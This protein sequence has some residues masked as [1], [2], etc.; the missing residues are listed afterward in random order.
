MKRRKKNLHLETKLKQVKS[1]CRVRAYIIPPGSPNEK[2]TSLKRFQIIINSHSVFSS[3][4]T[5]A[6]DIQRVRVCTC[7]C[8]CCVFRGAPGKLLLRFPLCPQDG[9]NG[10]RCSASMMELFWLLFVL[11][12][13]PS[14]S[15]SS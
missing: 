2:R 12:L 1:P 14:R 9:V 15:C 13:T 7:V 8:V 11:H 5:T 3:L 4:R 10:Q 6:G